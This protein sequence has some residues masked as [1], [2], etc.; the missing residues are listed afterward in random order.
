MTHVRL[1]GTS[2]CH[3]C[4]QAEVLLAQVACAQPLTWTTLDIAYDEVLLERFGTHI[5]V[6]QTA[7]GDVLYWPFSLVDIV[8]WLES[9]PKSV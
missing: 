3:L 2:A 5:P 6:L 9:S 4:E 7:S 1:L 8:R